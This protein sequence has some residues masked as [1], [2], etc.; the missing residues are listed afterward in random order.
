[1]ERGTAMEHVLPPL[2]NSVTGLYRS[3]L[4]H[5]RYSLGKQPDEVSARDLYRAV[6]YSARDRL[7]DRMSETL[8]RYRKNDA[9]RLYY[10]SM[11]F[12]IGRSL[13]KNLAALKLDGATGEVLRMF[14]RKMEE[15]LE[16]E[17]DSA[18]GNGGLGRLAA[19]YL[20]SLAT[21]S[22]PGFGYGIHYDYGL[23]KQ[24]INNG[25]QR[26]RPDSWIDGADAL[27]VE[28]S[29]L[30]VVVPLYGRIEHA[31]DRWG[32]YNPMW[33]DWK[34]VVGVPYDIPMAGWG[35]RSVN[36]L[37]LYVARP[38][39]DFDM[40]IFNQGD[41]FRAVE[42]KIDSEKISKILYPADTV[43]AGRELRLTQEYFL[44]ACAVRDIIRNYLAD[45]QGFDEFPDK[46]AIQLNDTHPSLAIAE[47]MRVLVDEYWLEWD[48]A[49]GITSKTVAYTNHTL[50]PEALEK[51]PVAL[52]ERVL[53]RHLQ[54]IYEI[55]RRFLD[56]VIEVWPGDFDRMGR[57]S[58][59]EEGPEK[60]A[61]MANLSIVGSHRVNGVSALHSDLVKSDLVPDFYAMWP[62][63]FTN[64]TN[65]IT[66]R[67]WLSRSNPG[68]CAL[69][70]EHLG[71]GFVTDLERLRALEPLAEDPAFGEKYLAVRREN[72]ERLSR[73]IFENAMISVDPDSIF[74][75]QAK[76][77]HEYKRQLLNVLSIMAE[78]ILIADDG[79]EPPAPKTA[80]FAG[81]AAPGYQ[82][83]KDMIKLI[84]SVADVVN[85]D[86]RTKG[87]LKVAFLPDYRVT[88]AEKMVCA[89]DLSQQISTA[90]YEASGTGNMKFALNGAVTIG[91][92]DGANIEIAREVGEENVLIFGLTAPEIARLTKEGSYRPAALY[93]KD[94][95]IRRVLDAL[96]DGRFSPSEPGLF[97]WV[98]PYLLSER[99]R[100]FHLADFTSYMAARK[101]AGEDF[102]DR[103][104]WAKKGILNT[105]RMGFFSSDRAIREYAEKIWKIES[106]PG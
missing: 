41:Y 77:I 93:Q 37:R 66:P 85:R 87:L 25:Y 65:G 29:D 80:I 97:A 79:V 3:V 52:L 68:L 32:Q 73:I 19:C 59:I 55:N 56:R 100:Y 30:A 38:S 106:V 27:H 28:R 14:G 39:T 40:K 86:K 34:L 101:K 90:G 71:P 95:L 67:R 96:R 89:A 5:L 63:K 102:T 98:V 49:W 46:V 64:V 11:E 92:L 42:Q 10:L 99:D 54:I 58:L 60:M 44:V 45:H 76:R 31:E 24:E 84:H 33:M 104:L 13:V 4:T 36:Y 94:T 20:D 81:K 88:L 2:E 53:P 72:K 43:S 18:L 61:R 16:E 82:T 50:L 91:T 78:Y 12:L 17:S 21:L 47:L 26:E 6:S 35:G 22:M 23:F 48:E 8:A 51:W 1:M 75:M 9:K 103:L 74:D 15:I 57:M 7:L 105:A 69:V 70:A 83:A 62:E